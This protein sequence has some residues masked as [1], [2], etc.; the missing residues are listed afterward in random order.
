MQGSVS[1]AV[2]V[3]YVKNLAPSRAFYG[4]FG[5]AEQRSGGDGDATWCYL[6]CGENT[7]LLAAVQPPLI[8]VELPLLIYFYVDDLAAVRTR[9][10]EAGHPVEL[11]GHPDHA[12]GGEA[13][14]VDPDGNAVLFGQR[15]AAAGDG[16]R[17]ATGDQ[18]R[19]SL[20]QQAAEAVS[21]RGGA[22]ATC[23]VGRTGGDPCPESAEVKLADPWG[24]TVWAC[25]THADEALIDARSAFIATEDEHG[26]GPWLRQRR[27]AG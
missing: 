17:A 25:L 12:R 13:R 16:R 21:R 23:Q 14:T 7:L 10:E 24:E 8:Q 1:A 5:Y 26:L 20:L 2:P 3:C 11:A 18:A 19:Q 6:Q 22:P 9:L 27:A 4:L 15:A